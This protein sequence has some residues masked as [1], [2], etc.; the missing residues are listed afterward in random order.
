MFLLLT[1]L[2][3][4][5]SLSF[6]CSV[7]EAVLLSTP[8]SYISLKES[9][10]AKNAKLLKKYKTDIDKPIAAILSLNTIAHTI[11]AAGVGAEATKVFGEASF[12]IVSA[13]MTLLILVLSEII[14]KTIGA[15]YWRTLAL[16]TTAV[17]HFLVII[18]Y[19]LV[20]LSEGITKVFSSN[21]QAVSVSREEVSSMVAVASEEGVL[22]DQES[23]IIQNTIKLNNVPAEQIMTPNLVVCSVPENTTVKELFAK[24]NISFSRIPVYTDNKDYITGYIL[25][26]V[27]LELL[28]N[29]HFDT[30]L[31]E[32][33]RDILKFN[34]DDSTFTIWEKMLAK[35]EHISVIHDKYGCLRGIVTLEDIIETMLGEEI[36]DEADTVVDMQQVALEK[37]KSMQALENSD[38]D[39]NDDPSEV[40]ET[41]E[42]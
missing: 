21:E 6:L 16:P 14:P 27:A 4:A 37:Y 38:D 24:G 31:S 36:V 34:E 29:D 20:R 8:M 18:T 33:R 30:P 35:K 42:E 9:E 2:I 11:G 40:T 13:V 7:L 32:I 23:K 22:K 19:P 10:G 28:A 26:S 25:K 17:I 41:S 12:G 39:D 1:Y 3:G 5:L 15:S